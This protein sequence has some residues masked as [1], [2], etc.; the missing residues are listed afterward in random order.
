MGLGVSGKI[1]QIANLFRHCFLQKGARVPSR[2]GEK[3]PRNLNGG[4][5]ARNGTSG[6]G[7]PNS[8]LWL[9]FN[10]QMFQLG[11]GPLN[12]NV[13]LSGKIRRLGIRPEKNRRKQTG[14]S[15]L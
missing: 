11:F 6:K 10:P 12:A 15:Q 14:K 7:R 3:A 9:V 8:N 4:V 5:Q 2:F 13:P 1:A